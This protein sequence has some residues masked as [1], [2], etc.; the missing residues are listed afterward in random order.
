LLRAAKL[1][2]KNLEIR[3][4]LANLNRMVKQF[5]TIEK[6][7]YSRMFQTESDTAA[8]HEKS[9]KSALSEELKTSLKNKMEMFQKN[10]EMREMVLPLEMSREEVE[11][12]EGI[13]ADMDSISTQRGTHVWLGPR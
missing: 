6:G 5:E 12:I 4:E 3:Q 1:S 10:Y 8:D 7:M 11:Y 9:S 2:P 13:A